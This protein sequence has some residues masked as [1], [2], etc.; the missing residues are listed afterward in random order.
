VYFVMASALFAGDEEVAARLT[1][2]LTAWRCWDDS[3]SVARSERSFRLLSIRGCAFN[4][5]RHLSLLLKQSY[6]YLNNTIGGN[7]FIVA[8]DSS[9]PDRR[10]CARLCVCGD[11]EV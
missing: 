7:S 11:H 1:E 3:W 10:E 9:R 8:E 2:T 6:S 5:L 4:D